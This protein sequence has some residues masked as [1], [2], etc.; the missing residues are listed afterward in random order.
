MR[1]YDGAD[2]SRSERAGSVEITEVWKKNI[3]SGPSI[4]PMMSLMKSVFVE[5]T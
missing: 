2:I 1:V 4:R 5:S 3:L